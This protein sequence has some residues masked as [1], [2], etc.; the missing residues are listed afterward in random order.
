MRPVTESVLKSMNH[1]DS[2]RSKYVLQKL[3]QTLH[4]YIDEVQLTQTEWETAIDFLT[5]TGHMCQGPRQEFI[6]LSDVLG[7]SM[8]VDEIN[9]SQNEQQTPSTVFGP[10]FVAGMPTR[11]YGSSI[12][13]EGSDQLMPLLVTGKILNHE[14]E[15]IVGAEIEVW[16]TADNGMYSGQDSTQPIANLRGKFLSNE[17][18]VYAFKSILPISYQ[19]PS[20]GT[21]GELLNYA[22][23][24]F[25]RPAHIHFMI[26][27]PGY[28]RLVTHLFIEGD[29]H[30]NGD[31]VF[32]VKDRL[33]VA[34]QTLTANGHWTEFFEPNQSFNLIPYTFVLTKEG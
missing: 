4:Q 17:Q 24:H 6:L 34:Y 10:F 11:A 18:G 3:I 25:W 21:V 22:K 31:A 8:L 20:D 26:K 23:R 5:R 30:L 28:Q 12:V 7:I 2:E 15:P 33:I 27:A 1:I 9:H 32:G 19:I 29:E 13:E 16:Q 14:A